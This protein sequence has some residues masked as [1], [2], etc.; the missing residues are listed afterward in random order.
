MTAS[1]CRCQ[2][3][4]FAAVLFDG[5]GRHEVED[6]AVVPLAVAVDAAHPLLEPV[7]ESGERILMFS[8]MNYR[9]FSRSL[10]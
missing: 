7:R 5:V 6:Q 9:V 2:S 8:R 10:S 1:G 3:A 4:I